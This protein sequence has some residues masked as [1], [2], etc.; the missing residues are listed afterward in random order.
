MESST[1]K[2]NFIGEIAKKGTEEA[3][4][5]SE[6]ATLALCALKAKNIH[7]LDDAKTLLRPHNTLGHRKL[8]ANWKD[9]CEVVSTTDPV[10]EGGVTVT[11]KIYKTRNEVDKVDNFPLSTEERT[12][13]EEVA[14]LKSGN[15]SFYFTFSEGFGV[16]F[17]S[18]VST[19]PTK[20]TPYVLEEIKGDKGDKVGKVVTTA[21]AYFQDTYKKPDDDAIYRVMARV[22][23]TDLLQEWTNKQAGSEAMFTEKAL[24]G[25]NWGKK[26]ILRF[27]EKGELEEIGGTIGDS[28]LVKK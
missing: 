10:V 3:K 15:F 27:F 12:L 26:T 19:E 14:G 4:T 1:D 5:A 9:Y 20:T 21:Y 22:V 2:Y 8:P 6:F 13:A 24:P 18:V 25:C 17:C 7:T 23:T 11:R 28:F 16:I